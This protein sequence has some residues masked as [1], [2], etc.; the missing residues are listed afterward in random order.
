MNSPRLS[1][2]AAVG[3]KN[4]DIGLNNQL[5]WHLPEDLKHFKDLTVGHTVVMGYKTYQ[6]IGRPLP[7]RTNIVISQDR[8]PPPPGCLLFHSIPEALAQGRAA[9]SG[10]AKGELFVIGGGQIY[11]QTIDLAERLYLTIVK[12]ERE[13]DTFFPDYCQFTK[14]V[15]EECANH[16]N[17]PFCFVILER[18]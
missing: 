7:G 13:G 6:S 11:R 18:E 5:L 15:S 1:L 2:I 14:K 12:D 8:V 3:V 17:P 4:R 10:K 16:S 9:E